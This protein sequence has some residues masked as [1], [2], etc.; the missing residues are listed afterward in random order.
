MLKI[1]AKGVE[2]MKNLTA[3]DPTGWLFQ[4]PYWNYSTTDSRTT[5]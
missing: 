4:L 1:Y 3:G 2:A 5:A